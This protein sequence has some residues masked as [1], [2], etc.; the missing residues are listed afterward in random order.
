MII[1]GKLKTMPTPGKA[2]HN[3]NRETKT[4]QILRKARTMTIPVK[5][6]KRNMM[7]ARTLNTM[8]TPGGNQRPCH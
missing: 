6:Q 7:T 2:I 1:Q 5:Q 3:D 8:G 4:I